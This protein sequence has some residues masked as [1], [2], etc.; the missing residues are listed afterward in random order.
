MA[1]TASITRTA[2]LVIAADALEQI[3]AEGYAEVIIKLRKMNDA[4]IK[5]NNAAKETQTKE[6]LINEGIDKALLAWMRET[7]TPVSA[8]MAMAQF[9]D[10]RTTQK[11]TCAFTR[12]INKGLITKAIDKGVMLYSVAEVA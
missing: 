6:Q 7:G 5:T 12:L 10:L 1:N 3:D 2:A 8:K 9:G 11:A 4:I